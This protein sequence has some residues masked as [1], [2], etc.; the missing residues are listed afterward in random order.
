MRTSEGGPYRCEKN[1]GGR[2][3]PSPYK[4]KS[5]VK[6]IRET[7]EGGVKPPLHEEPSVE[8]SCYGRGMEAEGD[9]MRS[10]RGRLVSRMGRSTSPGRA[11]DSRPSVRRKPWRAM[12]AV[13][14]FSRATMYSA[15]RW[16]SLRCD[17]R[18]RGFDASMSPYFS[19]MRV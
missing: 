5:D 11:G 3:K 1:P 16:K 6:E 13:Q 2:G 17:C 10:G 7:R 4:G 9:I 18:T 19:T 15:W 12:P 8:D 14:T